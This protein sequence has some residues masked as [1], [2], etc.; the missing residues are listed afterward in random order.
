M[1]TFALACLAG[2]LSILSPCVL[3]LLPIILGAAIAEHKLGP[4]VVAAG[5]AISFTVIGLFVALIGFS[6]GIDTG[7]F[8]T[9]AAFMMIAIGSLLIVS[10]LQI[11]LASAGGPVSNWIEQRFGGFAKAGLKGQFAV[12]L[13]MGAL[14]SPCVGPTLGAASILA[15]QGKDIPQVALTMLAFGFGAGMPLLIL[16]SFSREILLKFRN[17]LMSAGKKVKAAL[18][19]MFCLIGLSVLSGVDKSVES[20]LVQASPDWLTKLTTAF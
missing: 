4:L 6:V 2:I 10:Q 14:W 12:G 11:A 8:R 19:I 9:L 3:P 16:G 20:F 17:R 7:I 15:A 1:I 5:L 18:G 13:L